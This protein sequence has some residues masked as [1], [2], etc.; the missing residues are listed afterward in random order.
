MRTY[1]QRIHILV[2]GKSGEKKGPLS[3]RYT[4]VT[5]T[6]LLLAFFAL[7]SSVLRSINGEKYLAVFLISFSVLSF[8]F[9]VIVRENA[10]LT[11]IASYLIVFIFILFQIAA[12]LTGSDST[13][14]GPWIV[15]IPVV[16]IFLLGASQGIVV[17]TLFPVLLYGVDR[18]LESGIF[19]GFF[20]GL[21]FFHL[22][23]IIAGLL[24]FVFR[25]M[26]ED[27]KRLRETEEQVVAERQ[28]MINAQLMANAGS[29]VYS[30]PEGVVELSSGQQKIMG[31]L[32]KSRENASLSFEEFTRFLATEDLE[33]LKSINE[34]FKQSGA[35][36]ELSHQIVR[37][38]GQVRHV[39]GRAEPEYD[40]TGNLIRILGTS[41]DITERV[42][43][44]RELQKLNQTLE[45]RIQ[46]EVE[47]GREKE[48]ILF[49]QS[50]LASM[51]EMLNAIAHHWRQ[52]LS[53]VDL[54]IEDIYDAFTHNQLDQSY[55]DESMKE[56]KKHVHQ[57][58][59]TIDDFVRFSQSSSQEYDFYLLN[60]VQFIQRILSAQL[61]AHLIDLRL[62]FDE[63]CPEHC[64]VYGKP[65]D[66]EHVLLNVIN[67]AREAID[68]YRLNSPPEGWYG[69]ILIQMSIKDR[70]CQVS[71]EDNG[72]GIPEEV[73]ERLFEPYF[74][75]KKTGTGTGLY[76]AR[77]I[78]EHNMNGKLTVQNL[79]S[80]A[81]VEILLPVRG[82]K[83]IPEK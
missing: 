62:E 80:G 36:V 75:T 4:I 41:V 2:S 50:R 18:L 39:I 17:S 12:Y 74:T 3:Y 29:W 52:P 44:E 14:R 23:V 47:K 63:N 82:D 7:F 45:K 9:F 27:Q 20:P 30:I 59:A 48:R 67:N 33:R 56:A 81:V 28:K 60:T 21:D 31:I 68:A 69:T 13:G 83:V 40:E 49:Q 71:I 66:F 76:T 26:E 15:L 19:P 70:F 79:S 53:G 72:G 32:R 22:Y 5:Y 25:K 16:S 73:Q 24:F 6:L 64:M 35:P 34:S 65:Q 11:P 78:I 77:S 61:R 43:A 54:V 42:H 51:G 37:A 46:E 8:L 10:E 1:L 57:M 55:L 58:S 38:D